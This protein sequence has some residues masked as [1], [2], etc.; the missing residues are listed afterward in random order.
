MALNNPYNAYNQY[1]QNNVM[2]APPQEL[3]LMLYN[4]AIK[5]ANQAMLAIDEKNISKAH[6]LIL[7][8][9]DI[10]TELN[11]TLDMQYEISKNLRSLYVFILERLIDA[12][13]KKDKQYIAEAL[14]IIT[15]LR[16]TWKE[17][18]HLA[19]NK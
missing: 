16:D 3:T 9:S 6:Q 1:K 11:I 8:T 13:V 10:I 5:F 12:N 4:G 2:M 15:Q 19:K 14:E 7:R 18:M 17:A